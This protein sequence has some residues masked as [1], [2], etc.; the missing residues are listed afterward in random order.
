MAVQTTKDFCWFYFKK[1]P[2]VSLFLRV[3]FKLNSMF[4]ED[5]LD[6]RSSRE[7]K[8]MSKWSYVLEKSWSTMFKILWTMAATVLTLIP[9]HQ[10]R[11]WS[12]TLIVLVKRV[13]FRTTRADKPAGEIQQSPLWSQRRWHDAS[14]IDG[15][16]CRDFVFT[17]RKVERPI[18]TAYEVN[19]RSLWLQQGIKPIAKLAGWRKPRI[20]QHHL[21]EYH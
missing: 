18:W 16:F 19:R 17:N 9:N 14:R 3:V 20:Q 10:I 1:L 13:I 12:G 5:H 21:L 8:P 6:G 15:R 7:S 2:L 4:Q 11:Q